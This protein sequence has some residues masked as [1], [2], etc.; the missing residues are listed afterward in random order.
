MEKRTTSRLVNPTKYWGEL[1]DPVAAWIIYG[2]CALLGLV[3]LAFVADSELFKEV[4]NMNKPYILTLLWKQLLGSIIIIF[5]SGL[6]SFGFFY[7]VNKNY[8]KC[9]YSYNVGDNAVM[10]EIFD[11]NQIINMQ[12]N[13]GQELPAQ[14]IQVEELRKKIIITEMRDVYHIKLY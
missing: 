14:E 8:D 12:D 6:V 11:D 4:Y 9:K 3:S 13:R 10:E 5:F 2:F 1:D 7:I